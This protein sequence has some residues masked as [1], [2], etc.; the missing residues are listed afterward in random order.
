MGF[1]IRVRVWVRIIRVALE[2]D[3]GSGSGI[4]LGL[5]FRIVLGLRFRVVFGLGI[6]LGFVLELN[7]SMALE[8]LPQHQLT[9]KSRLPRRRNLR[10]M[11]TTRIPYLPLLIPLME[12][13]TASSHNV[14]MMIILKI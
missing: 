12:I 6:D 2:P 1:R 14:V 8:F 3:F 5:R 7:Y 10:V 13:H 4:V 9:E 11:S